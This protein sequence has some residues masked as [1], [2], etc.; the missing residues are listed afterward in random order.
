[1][2]SRFG[3]TDPKVFKALAS[4]AV[5]LELRGE[6]CCTKDMSLAYAQQ[7][8]FRTSIRHA[9]L[10]SAPPGPGHHASMDFTRTFERDVDGNICALVFLD[11]S[12]FML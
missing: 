6:D 9:A 4:S 10:P 3:V 5:G 12:T 2:H 8:S 1:M 11:V 7:A